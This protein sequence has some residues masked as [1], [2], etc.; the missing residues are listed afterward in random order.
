MYGDFSRLTVA[1]AR[2]R[3]YA[4]VLLQQGRV[5]LDA[6]WNELVALTAAHTEARMTDI[7]GRTGAPKR[8]AGFRIVRSGSSFTI[9]AG[10]YYVDGVMVENDARVSFEAQAERVVQPALTTLLADGETGIVYLD[11]WKEDVCAL[12]DI[13]L[14]EPALGGPDT[15]TRLKIAWHVGVQALGDTGLSIDAITHRARLGTPV[16]LPG[17]GAMRAGTSIPDHLPD[18]ADCLL[19]PE[20]GYLSQDNRL[21]RVEIHRGGTRN[22]ARFKWSRENGSVLARLERNAD[23]EFLLGG[24]VEDEALGFPDD[25][26]G[27]VFDDSD[28]HLGRAG[29]LRRMRRQ[30]DGTVAFTGGLG[31]SFDDMRNPRVRRWDQ[32]AGSSNLGLSMNAAAIVLEKGIEIAFQPG[33]Y[34][35]GDYWLI[36]ARAAT[37]TI[38]WPPAGLPP[39]GLG[40]PLAAAEAAP[41]FGWGRRRVPLAVIR[42]SGSGLAGPAADLRPV[43]SSLTQLEAVDVRFDNRI[44]DLGADTVQ[45]AVESL[46]TRGRGHCRIYAKDAGELQAAL[47]AVGHV[48]NLHVCLAEGDFILTSPLHFSGL[49]HLR[50]TGAGPETLITASRSEAAIDIEDCRRVE[51]FDLR[52]RGRSA[53]TEASSGRRGAITI[54]GSDSILI[55]R[56]DAECAWAQW[57]GQSC[58]S[59][60]GHRPTTHVVI[61]DCRLSVGQGQIGMQITDPRRAIVENNLIRATAPSAGTVASRFRRDTLLLRRIVAGA[62]ALPEG[63]GDRATILRGIRQPMEVSSRVGGARASIVVH[64]SLVAPIQSYLSARSRNL[65]IGSGTELFMHLRKALARAIRENGDYR[66]GGTRVRQFGPFVDSLIGRSV[67]YCEEGIVIAGSSVGEVHV[68]A[69]DIDGAIHGVRVAASSGSNPNPPRWRTAQPVNL[70]QRVIIEDNTVHNNPIGPTKP[71]TGIHIGHFDALIIRGNRIG[72]LLPSTGVDATFWMGIRTY[73]WRGPLMRIVENVIE[74]AR[75]GASV[76]PAIERPDGWC[77]DLVHNGCRHVTQP[78]DAGGSINTD[79]L[80]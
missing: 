42:R 1:N 16:W 30:P 14:R 65:S 72:F 27:E 8:D 64:P 34:R 17:S 28:R 49:N 69:N 48:R 61:R 11:V 31:R 25:V 71:S 43:F 22:Q 57:R 44:C 2:H 40:G 35:I 73:G 24:A 53:D 67:P 63:A 37:G 10:R 29:L 3:H 76:R 6:D 52:A 26:I 56:V 13:R 39:G 38:E 55:E 41:S 50:I 23:G 79:P 33:D 20:A 32:G 59:I 47:G 7:I 45:A 4:S 19:A 80:T 12:E 68:R 74:N 66:S 18:D 46:C 54:S 15:A 5:H 21:Y 36:P 75:V 77:W 60:Y 78:M 70:A 51:I 62:I 58:L 9:S